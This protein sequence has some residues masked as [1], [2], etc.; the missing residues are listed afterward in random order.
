MGCAQ[1][2]PK[3]SE[4]TVEPA[5]TPEPTTPLPVV[6]EPV[7]PP[8]TPTN[9]DDAM[10]PVVSSV[11]PDRGKVGAVG[12]S[13]V[14]TGVNFVP[15]S[16]IQ[17]DGAPLATSFVSGTELRAT[18]P[19]SRLAAVTSLRLSVGTSPP[20]GGASQEI[21]FEVENPSAMITSL[22]PLSVLAGSGATMLQVTGTDFVVGSTIVFGAT[23]LTTTFTSPT[24]LAATIP[25]D[26]LVTS[27]SIPVMVVNPAPGGGPSTNI[28][29]TVANPTA[30]I[31]EIS[32]SAALVGSAAVE[33]V[34]LGS[35]FV[36]GSSVLFNGGA[37][38]TTFIGDNELRATLPADSLGT[39]GDFPIAVSN[40]PPGGGVTTPVVFRV[41]YPV[42]QPLSLAPT[43]ASVGAGPTD[44]IVIGGGGFFITSLITFDGAPAATTYQDATHLKATL[45][46]A[47]LAS[48]GTIS[49]RVANAAPGGGPSSDLAFTVN[50]AVPSITWL[51]PS[52]VAAGSP[53]RT[54]TI[55][56]TGFV[57]TTRVT[58]NGVLVTSTYVN[59]STLT[60]VVP[61]LHLLNPGVVALTVTN[62]APGGG[63][64]AGSNLTVGCE[65]SGVDVALGAIGTTTTLATNFATA[66]R[67]SR[68][69]RG[70]LC[71]AAAFDPASPQPGRYWVVQNTAGAP[72]TLSAWADCA[73]D[74]K[75]GVAYL[76][77]YRRPTEPAN[78][79]ERLACAFVI[80]QG[81]A[82]GNYS[83]PESGASLWCPGLTKANGGGLQLGVC[84]KAVVHIQSWSLTSTTFT[85]PPIVRL[86]PELP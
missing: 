8:K 35:G 42:P 45:T 3:A 9:P 18:L 19:T 2:D 23:D 83:S 86:K 71:S 46:A 1:G 26:L 52:S 43:S 63:T 85:A 32:P 74:G 84:E 81:M 59:A 38:A 12:P 37:L 28:S 68:F 7:E 65:T 53:D 50:N 6:P 39:A 70:G 79:A 73:A 31:Q 20:G 60:A 62:P 66:P 13:I 27:G 47:Q 44:V 69:A 4:P 34:V 40:P 5:A 78:D 64:S 56:G 55:N 17:L 76:T 54:I 80:A 25:E 36:G 24:S 48:A 49:V 61:S 22:S 57:P 82:F 77:Y 72:V 75:Q 10:R 51:N 29:F 16:I 15:R 30:S 14:I 58:S 41:Q 11:S 67:M 33:L 21:T